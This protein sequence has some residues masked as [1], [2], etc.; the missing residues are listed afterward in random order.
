MPR[1]VQL[2][3]VL[4]A[5]MTLGTGD[6]EVEDLTEASKTEPQMSYNP[7]YSVLLFS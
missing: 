7:A 4:D 5:I 2:F 3:G 6:R 1:A